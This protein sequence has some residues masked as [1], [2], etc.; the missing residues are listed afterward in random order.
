M[1]AI[2]HVPRMH[3]R[4]RRRVRRLL[5]LALAGG[6]IATAVLRK[7]RALRAEEKQAQPD[8]DSWEDDGGAQVP[9]AAPLNP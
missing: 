4:L 2:T 8:L 9:A 1:D 7:R 6:A 5:A 3:V